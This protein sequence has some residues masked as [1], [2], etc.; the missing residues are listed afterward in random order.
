MKILAIALLLVN[1]GLLAWQYQ[2]HVQT[3]AR[4]HVAHEPLPSDAAA[5]QLVAELP[6][7][8]AL[9]EPQTAAVP[10]PVTAEVQADVV[11]A[12]L[13]VD[14]GP[15]GDAHETWSGDLTAAAGMQS[16]PAFPHVQRHDL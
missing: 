5:I 11:A 1:V 16:L 10:P 4:R 12:D 2:S 9:R 7:L 3:L 13:C 8:P 15:F 14:V 6:A